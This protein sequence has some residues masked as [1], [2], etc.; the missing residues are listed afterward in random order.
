MLRSAKEIMGYKLKA[1]DGELGRSKD[2]LFDDEHWTIRYLVAD[3]GD[4][5]R[6]RRVLISPI[7]IDGSD[8]DS[9]L[10]PVRLL[11]GQIENAPNLDEEKPVSRQYEI[12]FFKYN[13]WPYY[14][15]G[16]FPWGIV[17]T[18][19]GMNTQTVAE[20]GKADDIPPGDKHL[21]S[22]L[23][24][25]G[26]NISAADGDIGHIDDFII[27]DETWTIRYLIVD[28]RNWLPGKK[29]IV[30]PFWAKR[31]DWAKSKVFFGVNRD[32]IKN[33]P[34]YDP[35]MPIT[36]DY[37]EHLHDYYGILNYWF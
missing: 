29:V 24:V 20:E 31:V 16:G 21:R 13:N 8:W 1:L 22:M 19:G 10:L 6:G 14:W 18:P 23:E 27:D 28:T 3:T 17:N 34:E 32:K 11:K 2:F 4:W 7:S 36:R 12:E 35:S 30:S 15:N 5:L 33:S 25:K 26:Y 9:K 37:E